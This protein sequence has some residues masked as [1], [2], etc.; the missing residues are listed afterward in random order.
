MAYEGINLEYDKILEVVKLLHNKYG[1]LV[2][3]IK[4]L[5]DRVNLLVEDGLV[6]KQSSEVIRETYDKFNTSLNLAVE[7]IEGFSKMFD[8]IKTNAEKFDSDLKEAIL[9]PKS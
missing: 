4:G 6:F 9:N 5:H 7:G 2:P 8:N 3:Q 1:E